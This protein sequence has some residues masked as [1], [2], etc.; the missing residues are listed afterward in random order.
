MQ[1]RER[2][3]VR[4]KR[5]AKRQRQCEEL[6][7]LPDEDPPVVAFDTDQSE[8]NVEMWI[9]GYV[10]QGPKALIVEGSGTS[11]IDGSYRRYSKVSSG[12]PC[13]HKVGK[14]TMYNV[15]ILAYGIPKNCVSVRSSEQENARRE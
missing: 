10:S 15:F 5:E 13:Y 3:E 14:R 4:Q 11:K 2:D 1:K 7:V 9:C 8:C 6:A 12:R